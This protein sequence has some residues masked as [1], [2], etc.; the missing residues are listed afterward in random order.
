MTRIGWFLL[1]IGLA[2]GIIFGLYYAWE[3]SPTMFTQAS[4]SDLQPPYQDQYRTLVALAFSS[5]G[6]LR[7]ATIRLR[8]LPSE[9]P[10]KDLIALAQRHLAEGRP[11]DETEALALLAATLLDA[12]QTQIAAIE[13]STPGTPKAEI[14][15]SPSPSPTRDATRAPTITATMPPPFRLSSI[16][17][18]CNPALERPLIQVEILDREGDPLPGVQIIAIW[19]EGEDRFFTGLKPELGLGYADFTMEVGRSY[20]IQIAN[21]VEPVSGIQAGTCNGL[22]N[23]TYPGSWK[24]IFQSQ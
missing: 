15:P 18:I 13:G 2:L 12:E 3:I 1:V 11:E 4:P 23:A 24:L 10:S 6:D 20:A 14:P 17:S 16:E 22:G 7:R 21:G 8:R 9:D 19:D 5:T